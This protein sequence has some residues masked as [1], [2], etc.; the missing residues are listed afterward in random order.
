MSGQQQQL[1]KGMIAMIMK[2][3]T[4]PDRNGNSRAL[5]IVFANHRVDERG[6]LVFWPRP[7]P[8]VYH[9]HYGCWGP[10]RDLINIFGIRPIEVDIPPATY[11]EILSNKYNEW[12]I[13]SHNG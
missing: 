7:R 6:E 12:E 3:K 2:Y 1:L 11:R 5:W 8:S 4:K 9:D 13:M 10:V